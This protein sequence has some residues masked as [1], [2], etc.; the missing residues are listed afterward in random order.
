MFEIKDWD[1]RFDVQGLFWGI[2]GLGYD[3]HGRWFYC[4][5]VQVSVEGLG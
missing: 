4:S 2:W 1:S 3:I 5:G